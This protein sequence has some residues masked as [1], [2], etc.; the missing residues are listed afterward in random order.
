MK[1]IFKISSKVL[2]ITLLIISVALNAIFLYDKHITNT[3]WYLHLNSAN[4]WDNY[5]TV[6]NIR[7]AQKISKGKGIKVGILDWGFGCSEHPELYTDNKDFL[8]NSHN[9]NKESQ[10]G[11]WMAST[12][13][14]I[15]PECEI[16]ALSTH[17]RRESDKVK[18]MS[19]AIDWAIDNK[20][21]VLTYSDAPIESD[22]NRSILDDA[23]S[24]AN[25]HGIVTTFIHYDN[26]L[27]IQPGS[28]YDKNDGI[29]SDF[30]IYSYD[31]N[32][33]LIDNFKKYGN[34][35]I[36]TDKTSQLYMSYSS[37][38]PVTAGFVAILKSIN[39]NLT[40]A[41]YKEILV[42]T[43]KEKTITEP[44]TMKQITLPKVADINDAVNYMQKNY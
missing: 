19:E 14:E 18:A 13:K 25:E 34:D 30:T 6:H 31:Y 23:V 1:K 36:S 29:V 38:S 35:N 3:V 44:N 26:P 4:S 10:H 20:L 33:L 43:A 21:D 8:N 16:Y 22:E 7:E 24:K 17:A 15:T 40:P 12:L 11:Y 37:M 28:M 5:F 41:Q 32:L 9:H 39:P 27:N 2:F 42:S